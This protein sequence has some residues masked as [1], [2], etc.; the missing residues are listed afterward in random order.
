M[1]DLAFIKI[2][3][4]GTA[5]VN[6]DENDLEPD[7]TGDFLTVTGH[8]YVLQNLLK[9][10][11]TALKSDPIT[12][13]YGT[14]MGSAVGQRDTNS[15]EIIRASIVRAVAFLIEVET[16]QDPSERI[17]GIKRTTVTMDTDNV[18]KI[19]T[20]TVML[21]DGQELTAQRRS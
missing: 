5:L 16:S 14:V 2:P 1:K 13:A 12:P 6:A 9:I 3:A 20:I 8:A 7:G 21:E 15:N 11:L 18:T 4:G 19:V 10:L 17:Q